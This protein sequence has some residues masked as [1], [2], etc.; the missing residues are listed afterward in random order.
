[1]NTIIGNRYKINKYIDKGSSGLVYEAYDTQLNKII[2]VKHFK[3]RI[4][5]NLE[6]VPLSESMLFEYENNKQKVID[7]EQ[8]IEICL[9]LAHPSILAYY[10]VVHS[11]DSIYLIM[12]Y[13]QENLYKKIKS[14][15]L[16]E[17][18]VKKYIVSIM[19]GIE[20]LHQQNITHRDIKAANILLCNDKPK[21]SDFGLSTYVNKLIPN[22]LDDVNKSKIEGSVYWMAPEII[23]GDQLTLSSDIWS[24]GCL[25][26][27]L[28]HGQPPFYDRRS[29]FNVMYHISQNNESPIPSQLID[30]ISKDCLEFLNLCFERIYSKRWTITQLLKHPWISRDDYTTISNSVSVENIKISSTLNNSIPGVNQTPLHSISDSF[31]LLEDMKKTDIEKSVVE[32]LFGDQFEREKWLEQGGIQHVVEKMVVS[33]PQDIKA[34]FFHFF[35]FILCCDYDNVPKAET[36]C[37]DSIYYYT[38]INLSVDLPFKIQNSKFFNKLGNTVFWK[39]VIWTSLPVNEF[40]HFFYICSIKQDIDHCEHSLITNVN[41][42]K[43]FSNQE[44]HS[45]CRNV[46]YSQISIRVEK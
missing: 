1:M 35:K 33:K 22:H 16:S 8:E 44:N 31:D 43:Y 24:L 45:Y 2:A 39:P 4:Y 29:A 27:E 12:E 23:Q 38:K 10:D 32:H 3:L 37:V 46:I 11:N 13:A 19:Q 6:T 20:Y 34:I 30:N 18:K 41:L 40:L 42:L 5:N 15:P 21:I 26:V 9:N 36:Q 17:V 14:M 28:L 7:I 25:I